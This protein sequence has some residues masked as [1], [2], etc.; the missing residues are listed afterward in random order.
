MRQV[1][2]ST[3]AE[4]GFVCLF[5]FYH[6]LVF[7]SMKPI[8]WEKSKQ[9]KVL[10]GRS[11]RLRKKLKDGKKF[12]SQIHSGISLS[13]LCARPELCVHFH[14]PTSTSFPTPMS[15]P[16]CDPTPPPTAPVPPPFRINCSS[17]R[18]PKAFHTLLS[19]NIHIIII[20]VIR[21]VTLILINIVVL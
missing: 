8:Y 7:F 1:R 16:L 12:T 10:L 6:S 17:L 13:G 3:M 19:T 9:D 20:I 21:I 4:R 2:R 11:F 5:V 14:S 15:H 18:T